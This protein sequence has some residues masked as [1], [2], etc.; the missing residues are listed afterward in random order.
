MGKQVTM[1][2]KSE[3]VK[4]KIL[5]NS[6]NRLTFNQNINWVIDKQELEK[7]KTADM[8][9][10]KNLQSVC[11]KDHLEKWPTMTGS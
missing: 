10:I 7:D 3:Q 6:D 9:M 1:G 8:N 4:Q 2:R 5:I 11:T